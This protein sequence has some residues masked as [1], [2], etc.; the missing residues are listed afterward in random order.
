MWAITHV[1]S[2]TLITNYNGSLFYSEKEA[3]HFLL[4]VKRL[5]D[6]LRTIYKFDAVCEMKATRYNGP[7]FFL[8][9]KPGKDNYLK[10]RFFVNQRRHDACEEET[11]RMLIHFGLTLNLIPD[12]KITPFYEQINKAYLYFIIHRVN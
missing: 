12:N 4:Q 9:A 8:G 2:G 11:K 1:T 5:L 10:V 7:L 3:R 6:T